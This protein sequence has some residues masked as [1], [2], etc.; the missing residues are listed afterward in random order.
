MKL[1]KVSLDLLQYLRAN[2]VFSFHFNPPTVRNQVTVSTPLDTSFELKCIHEGINLVKS[3]LQTK[4]KTTYEEDLVIFDKLQ[5]GTLDPMPKNPWR[6]KLALIHRINQKE[7]L[8]GQIKY[9][10]LLQAI[11]LRCQSFLNEH[12]AS[13][14]KDFRNIYMTRVEEHETEEDIVVNRI[15]LRHYLLEYVQN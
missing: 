5:E 8:L 2:L 9:F 13:T 14:L 12:E 7:I 11:L 6:L 15:V 1:H 4:F 3:M 10:G